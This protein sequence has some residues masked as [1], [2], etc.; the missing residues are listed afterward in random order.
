MKEAI[1]LPKIPAA[2]WKKILKKYDP[3]EDFI[4]L[5]EHI[6]VYD[7]KERYQPIDALMHPYF[8]ELPKLGEIL[9]GLPN[10]L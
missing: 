6:M 8:H 9:I 4:D 2:G 5:I 7:V 1:I 3:E 10:L